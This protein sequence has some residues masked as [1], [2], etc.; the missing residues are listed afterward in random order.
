MGKAETV[1]ETPHTWFFLAK[2][3]KVQL[4]CNGIRRLSLSPGRRSRGLTPVFLVAGDRE[5]RCLVC[6]HREGGIVRQLL[7]LPGAAEGSQWPPEPGR[8]SKVGQTNSYSLVRPATPTPG[9][10]HR[11]NS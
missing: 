6:R 1:K 11:L 5:V 2:A 4:C 10:L 9:E 3:D 8:G 7:D